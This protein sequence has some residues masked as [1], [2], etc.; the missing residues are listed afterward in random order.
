MH[1]IYY[2]CIKLHAEQIKG[3][4]SSGFVAGL[5]RIVLELDSGEP[6]KFQKSKSTVSAC[7]ILP[8]LDVKK[9]TKQIPKPDL[10]IGVGGT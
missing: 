9:N 1:H 6:T 5:G 4:I 7:I 3:Q 2:Q 8:S 10:K